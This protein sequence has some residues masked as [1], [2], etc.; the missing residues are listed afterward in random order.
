[1]HALTFMA[2][3]RAKWERHERMM[4]CTKAVITVEVRLALRPLSISSVSY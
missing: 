4:Y 3:V 1:M 2:T